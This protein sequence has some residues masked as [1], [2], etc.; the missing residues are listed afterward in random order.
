MRFKFPPIFSKLPL[1][2]IFII[3]FVIQVLVTVGIIGY[4]SFITGEKSVNDLASQLMMT[5]TQRIEDNLESYLQ[6]PEIIN[7][8]NAADLKLGILDSKDLKMIQRHFWQQMHIFDKA[9]A[10]LITTDTKDFLIVER[11]NKEFI[12]RIF[13]QSTQGKQYNYRLDAQGNIKELTSHN[14]VYNPHDD[15]PGNPW[16]KRTLKANKS[17]WIHTVSLPKGELNPVLILANFQPFFNQQGQVKGVV[18]SAFHLS[19]MSRFLAHLS[20]GKTGFAF[21]M[22]T[23]GL[24]VATSTG[25]ATYTKQVESTMKENVDPNKRRKSALKSHHDLTQ[26]TSQFLLNQLVHFQYIISPQQFKFRIQ[27]KDY[28]LTVTPTQQD[29]QLNW[30]TVIVVPESDFMEKINANTLQTILLSAIALVVSIMIGILTANYIIRPILQLNK[31]SKKL[32]QGNWQHNI[33]INRHDEVGELAISFNFMAKQ[34]HES[35]ATLE[36]RVKNRTAE[37]EI[38][39]ETAI[40]AN[41]AKSEF[42]A[43]MSHEIRTPMNA[44]LGFS[45]ILNNLITDS[46]QRYYLDAIQ[47]SGKTLLQLINDILD[48]S[49]IEAGKLELRYSEVAIKA[50]CEDIAII[51]QQKLNDND[52][53]FAIELADNLPAVLRLDETRLRQVLLNIVSNAVKFTHQGFIRLSV[54]CKPS[55]DRPSFI[56]LIIDIE[57]SGIGIPAEQVETIFSAFTQQTNQSVQYGGTGL[58][59][60]ICKKLIEMM[61]GT[62]SVCSQASKGSCFTLALPAVEICTFPSFTA[63]NESCLPSA[64]VRFQPATLLLVDDIESNR[65]LIKAYLYSYPELRIIEAETGA[66]ALALIA[67]Q[68]FDLIFMDRRLPDLDGDS[69]CQKIKAMPDKAA[70]PII[71]ITASALFLPEE[72]HSPF[73]NLQLNKPI[74]KP[75]LLFALQSLLALQDETKITASV[76]TA[77]ATDGLVEQPQSVENWFEL[78]ALLRSH[79]LPQITKLNNEGGLQINDFIE[80]AEELLPLAETYSC[81][82]LADWAMMLKNQAELFDITALPKTLSDFENLIKQS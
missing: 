36:N 33:I 39:K 41:H 4:F 78:V 25:E 40:A 56:E 69:V 79:Y 60:T 45:D 55:A 70:I 29:K 44:V 10:A 17:L 31:A 63:G 2:L 9:S 53:H 19:E 26:K 73:Y 6:I 42:L 5:I 1:K 62:I 18:S 59:L 65:L 51:Y 13:N 82:P 22:D 27:N 64:S 46:T 71:M 14:R 21:I 47:R 80:I 43:N 52:I 54:A 81:Q 20:I 58:G 67:A 68:D 35:F 50:I 74:T 8:T 72:Q 11:V 24:L 57:D 32:A 77:A 16:Y 34:L 66:Q 38:A 12:L 75:E 7:R 30:L 23:Q 49:K 37:L 61:G 48:L 76:V 3:P 15:P 28:F